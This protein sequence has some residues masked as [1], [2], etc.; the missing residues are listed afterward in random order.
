MIQYRK[1]YQEYFSVEGLKQLRAFCIQFE[2]NYSK[3]NRKLY[4]A[5]TLDLSKRKSDFYLRS[6]L[7]LRASELSKHLT[8]GENL[9]QFVGLGR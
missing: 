8:L 2:I 5:E 1:F 4:L 9:I 7:R 3:N 6:Y